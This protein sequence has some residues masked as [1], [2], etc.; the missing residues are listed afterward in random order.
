MTKSALV[1]DDKYIGIYDPKLTH[2][3]VSITTTSDEI[4]AGYDNASPISERIAAIEKLAALGFDVCVR[5]SPFIPEQVDFDV[6]NNIK[7]NKILV[8]FLRVNS[9]I[10]KIFDLDYSEYTLRQ[11][12]YWHLPLDKK[13]EYLSKITGFAEISVCEDEDGAYE[14]W[15]ENVNYNKDDCCNLRK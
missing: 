3:Q 2:I 9:A 13:I 6:L 7:C 10:R 12:N 4:A 1:A 14:Y 8:E 5:L 15:K 11:G